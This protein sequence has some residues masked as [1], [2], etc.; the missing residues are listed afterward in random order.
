MAFDIKGWQRGHMIGVVGSGQ[1]S[2]KYKH[3]YVTNDD[4]ATIQAANYF[5]PLAAQVSKGDLFEVSID[6][7]GTAVTKS[8]VVSSANGATTVTLA[9]QT[10][11]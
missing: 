4:A 9:L 2:V 6:V 7:D 11:T 5:N 10:T 8:Y 3:F 1:Y